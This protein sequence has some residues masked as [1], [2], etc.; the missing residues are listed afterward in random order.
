MDAIESLKNRIRGWLPKEPLLPTYQKT[1]NNSLAYSYRWPAVGV[2]V[3][4]FEGA[5][6]S[7]LGEFLG[8]TNGVRVYAWL[9]IVILIVAASVAM[10]NWVWI[11]RTV[12]KT[13]VETC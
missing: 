11:K 1:I 8:F 4:T 2:V 7:L 13:K 9:I 5:L 12:T 10:W 3:G 6:L